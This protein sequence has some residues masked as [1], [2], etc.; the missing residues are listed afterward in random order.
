[1]KTIALIILVGAIVRHCSSFWIGDLL[2]VDARIVFYILGGYWELVLACVIAYLTWRS[3]WWP[4]IAF[5]CVIF[6]TEGLQMGVCRMFAEGGKGNLCSVATGLPI[7]A[8]ATALYASCVCYFSR[9]DTMKLPMVLIPLIASADVAYQVSPLAGGV[10][11][12]I[13]V[14]LRGLH[15][16]TL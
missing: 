15:G 1:V 13:C 3:E 11:L 2:G 10:T 5:G 7:G 16:R 8:T 14:A 6:G 4:M 9:V 12:S